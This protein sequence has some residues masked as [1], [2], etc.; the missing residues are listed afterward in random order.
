MSATNDDREL[1]MPSDVRALA[2]MP[3]AV[4]P[5]L[6]FHDDPR[7]LDLW[8]HAV[9]AFLW[10]SGLAIVLP[11]ANA[12]TDTVLMAG[13]AI[14]W[15]ATTIAYVRGQGWHPIAGAKLRRAR[16]LYA[17]D[18]DAGL[19][20]MRELAAS[21]VGGSIRTGPNRQCSLPSA[22]VKNMVGTP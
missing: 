1:H 14:G 18:A 8:R 20:A 3:R 6:R 13:A 10:L 2:K 4:A 21:P 15:L 5:A 11:M 12:V 22:R 19:S 16:A 17:S 7:S 9:N